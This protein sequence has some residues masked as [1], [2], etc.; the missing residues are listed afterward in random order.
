MVR[1]EGMV[2]REGLGVC[3]CFWILSRV[4]FMLYVLC[5]CLL[6]L[7]C[8]VL[9]CWTPCMRILRVKEIMPD[10]SD[11]VLW[12][13]RY[14]WRL[15][16][17]GILAYEKHTWCWGGYFRFTLSKAR[18][19]TCAAMQPMLSSVAVRGRIWHAAHAL[20]RDKSVLSSLWRKNQVDFYGEP[21][22]SGHLFF[23][24]P[25]RAHFWNRAE[26]MLH[27]FVYQWEVQV[28]IYV[29]RQRSE[30]NKE[31]IGSLYIYT[32]I[33]MGINNNKSLLT[34]IHRSTVCCSEIF[35]R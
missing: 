4:V 6:W 26:K 33:P 18:L 32:S 22:N 31:T 8:F 7:W 29:D 28:Y 24:K 35:I 23:Q 1:T 20:A 9:K 10:C 34:M 13:L 27:I 5:I 30:I 12:K 25:K 17:G 2:R 3:T 21:W 11:A 14:S 15:F 16:A 19:F